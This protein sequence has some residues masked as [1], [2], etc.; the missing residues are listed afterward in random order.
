VFACRNAHAVPAPGGG[1][2]VP[3]PIDDDTAVTLAPE[4]CRACG[5]L[6]NRGVEGVPIRT[7]PYPTIGGIAAGTQELVACICA[8]DSSQAS[9]SELARR[10]L[11]ITATAGNLSFFALHVRVS[12][13]ISIT[14]NCIPDN[15]VRYSCR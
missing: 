3:V 1:T 4:L 11:A 13:V 14:D 10:Y 2:V 8:C 9:A 5:T 12:R 6:E 15:V 7:A